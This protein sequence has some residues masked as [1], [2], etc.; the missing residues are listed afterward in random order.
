[1]SFSD[2]NQYSKL[3]RS[4]V[5]GKSFV[6]TGLTSFS[7]LL[8][9]N[10]LSEISD[11]KI[12]F[13]TADE[14]DALR[15]QNDLKTLFDKDSQLLPFQNLSFYETM[16]PNLYDY[17]SQIKILNGANDIVISPIKTLLEKFPNR[18][19]F[20]TNSLRFKIGDEIDQRQ[21]AQTLVNLGYKKAVTVTD[22]GE[23]SV[24]GDIIDV[25]SL[26]DNP[27]RIE[28]W[29]DEIV[30][31]RYFNNETQR[32]I[33]KIKSATIRPIYKFI[34]K[35][36]VKLPFETEESGYFEG[37]N[38]YQSYYNDELVG[39]F[40]Y[41]E[42]YMVVFNE[43]SE[44]LSKFELIEKSYEQQYLENLK[45]SMIYELKGK[46]H[47]TLEE[48]LAQIQGKQKIGLNNFL[49][50]ELEENFDLNSEGLSVNGVESSVAELK[51]YRDFEITVS[52]DFPKRVEE[53]L[54]QNGILNYEIKESIS[55]KG[56]IVRELKKLL[57][58][59]RELF[60]KR[61][62]NIVRAKKSYFK[63]KP[64]YIESINDI[65]EGEYVVHTIHGI[66]I[67]RGLSQL[68]IEGQLKDYLTIEYAN[69]DKLHMSAEQINMLC[70]YRGS[71]MLRP[72]I[73]RIGGTDWTN[74]KSN[75]KKEVEKIAYDLLRQ[76]GR[77]HV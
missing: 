20:E 71:G 49:D 63:E 28:L 1:M 48:F 74:T 23:F 38:V 36:A 3:K 18:K 35:D 29:G 59:D 11:K 32:Q 24:R 7:R 44:I 45:M 13:I 41:F 37:I 50:F 40:D 30:D 5:N 10:E 22:V 46:N 21:I 68:E 66:G 9:L 56:S 8:A 64:E 39:V 62:K 15:Y 67:Y 55:A 6:I 72:R 76:I 70:R 17:A 4:T 75:V 12:L 19:F 57:I 42:D 58:T 43:M 73:S 27:L 31:L 65:K 34:H 53:I 54:T 69:K 51:K 33:E 2:F 14:Q 60:N 47:F 77:A 52:T 61:S 16:L 25:F 26:D